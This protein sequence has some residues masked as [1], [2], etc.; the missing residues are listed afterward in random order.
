LFSAVYGKD[1]SVKWFVRWR[2]FFM[3]CAELWGYRN[4][5]EWIVSHYLFEVAA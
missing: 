3:A 5:S 4:G 2:V 1:N